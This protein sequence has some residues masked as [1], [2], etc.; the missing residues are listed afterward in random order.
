MYPTQITTLLFA[1]NVFH[2][3]FKQNTPLFLAGFPLYTSS[4]LYHF[5]KHSYPP[6]VRTTIPLCQIDFFLC[7]V[8]YFAALYDFFTRRTG[9][10][11]PP[12]S[13]FCVTMHVLMPGMFLIARP[14]KT[15]MWSDDLVV[16]ERWHAIFHLLINLD[17]HV[18]LYNTNT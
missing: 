11:K 17:T 1:T 6:N 18:Y 7:Y 13:H 9:G 8:Y 5:I 10:I 16:S 2:S 4:L 12:Y 3:Y 14:Y 15:L